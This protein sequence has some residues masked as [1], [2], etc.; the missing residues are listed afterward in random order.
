[1]PANPNSQAPNAT[2][3]DPDSNAVMSKGKVAARWTQN[4]RTVSMFHAFHQRFISRP[5]WQTGMKSFFPIFLNQLEQFIRD[6][7][8]GNVV[9]KL[10]QASMQPDVKR[11]NRGLD[12]LL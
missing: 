9:V 10:M 4:T 3:E 8:S 2:I 1:M 7:L 11:S 12:L 5:V 6:R